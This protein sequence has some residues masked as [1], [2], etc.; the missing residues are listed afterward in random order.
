MLQLNRDILMGET[1]DFER[2]WLSLFSECLDQEVGEEH[3]RQI[4]KGSE[5]F[6]DSADRGD[7]I[8][9]TIEAMESLEKAVDERQRIAVM[10]GCA[11]RYPA[12]GLEDIRAKYE[13]TGDL[14]KVH[15]M[16]QQK[17]ED[18]LQNNLDLEQELVDEVVSLGWGLAGILDGKTI[19]ATKIPKSGNL[20]RYFE[21]SDP[22]ARRGLYCHCP[23]VR[24]TVNSTEMIPITYG[25]CGAGFYKDIWERIIQEPVDVEVQESVPTGG[26]VCRIAIY[27]P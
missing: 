26:D 11:C 17:F 3:R 18:F 7:I 12:S 1:W 20:K 14:R 22:A 15:S 10:T 23:R 2:N 9:W 24:D 25:Y 16:L 19:S 5:G 27:L 21:E 6:S 13:E 8:H 4:L